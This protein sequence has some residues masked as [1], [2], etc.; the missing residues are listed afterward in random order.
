MSVLPAVIGTGLALALAGCGGGSDSDDSVSDGGLTVLH[1]PST[2]TPAAGPATGP[3]VRICDRSLAAEIGPV[4][5]AHDSGG[6]LDPR[7]HASGTGQL[8][9]CDLGPVELTLDAANHAVRRYRNRITE[10]AQF[11][12]SIP[13]HVPRPVRGVGDP[14]LGAAGANWIPFL[15]QLLSARGER[16]LIVTV[17][18]GGLSDP[19]RLA[20]AKETSLVVY[21]RL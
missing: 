17:N 14:D 9:A 13:S 4:L 15:H 18:G 1:T 7:P 12:Q 6:H 21:Q 5:E 16:V 2:T 20:A 19:E 3:L 11:S 10:T 8:S